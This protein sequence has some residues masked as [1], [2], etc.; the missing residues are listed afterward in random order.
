[1]P[2]YY[3]AWLSMSSQDSYLATD[4]QISASAGVSLL[5]A[6]ILGYV[7]PTVL[8]YYPWGSF[9]ALSKATA[10][11]QPAPFFP[12][13]LI[14]VA[15]LVWRPSPGK[16]NQKNGDLAQLER[17]YLFSAAICSALHLAIGVAIMT[18]TDPRISLSSVLLLNSQTYKID[19]AH[20]LHW[21]FAWDFWFCFLSSLLW[22]LISVTDVLRV[23]GELTAIAMA[24]AALAIRLLSVI[25]GPGSALPIVWYWRERKLVELEDKARSTRKTKAN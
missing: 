2:L 18:S 17:I 11:W 13:I 21:I 9:A 14:W 24:K 19:M 16:L 6:L 25:T 20:G 12:N 8:V 10:L 23:S 5:P 7:V 15:S 22:L 4:R 1:L 3:A